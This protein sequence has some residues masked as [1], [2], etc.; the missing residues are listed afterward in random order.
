MSVLLHRKQSS[1]PPPQAWKLQ[2]QLEQAAVAQMRPAEM[3]C[4]RK[5]A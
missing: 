5:T 2:I 1:G 4:H 3:V